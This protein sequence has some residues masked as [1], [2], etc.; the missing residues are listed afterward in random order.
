MYDINEFVWAV[1]VVWVVRMV[2]GIGHG[3]YRC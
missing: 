3:R 1:S 2:W